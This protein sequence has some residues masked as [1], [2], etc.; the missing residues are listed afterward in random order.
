MKRIR[1]FALTLLLSLLFIAPSAAAQSNVPANLPDLLEWIATGGA[2]AVI[3]AIL[4]WALPAIPVFAQWWD[5]QAPKLQQLYTVLATNIFGLISVLVQFGMKY[6][7]P[8]ATGTAWVEL[9]IVYLV[10][11]LFS[12]MAVR[13]VLVSN[14]IAQRMFERDRIAYRNALK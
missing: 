5:G 12:G 14:R 3:A 6:K 8:P 13:Q 2:A 4:N 10:I 7:P 9:V 11:P 1:L